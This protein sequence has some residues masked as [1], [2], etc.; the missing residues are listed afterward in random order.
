M[1]AILELV[2]TYTCMVLKELKKMWIKLQI[3]FL[4]LIN[5][6]VRKG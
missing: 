3:A 1:P 5:L 6:F 4:K 2:Q